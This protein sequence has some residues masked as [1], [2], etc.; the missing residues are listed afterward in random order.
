[1]RIPIVGV[2]SIVELFHLPAMLRYVSKE[3]VSISDIS[4]SRCDYIANKF[5]VRIIAEPLPSHTLDLILIAV[6]PHARKN[7]IE[8]VLPLNADILIEKPV[9]LSFEDYTSIS[10]L[11]A[12]RTNRVYVSHNR[13]YFPNIHALRSIF[14]AEMPPDGTSVN[15]F[16]GGGMS[17]LSFSSHMSGATTIDDKGVLQDV[18]VHLFDTL[19]YIFGTQILDGTVSGA[20]VDDTTYPNSIELKLT[21]QN[22]VVHIGM[23]RAKILANLLKIKEKS[24][25][26]FTRVLWDNNIGVILENDRTTFRCDDFTYGVGVSASFDHLWADVIE[27]G[28]EVSRLDSFNNYETHCRLLS[29]VIQKIG[30]LK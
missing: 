22:F 5:G 27:E 29:A 23:S 20:V 30:S 9:A 8:R 7:A 11:L 16:E 10:K 15:I 26:V 21:R 19:A 18:G 6:P 1:M 17:W 13:R 28:L 25:T 2:G 14:K 4:K 24:R 3:E 12:G